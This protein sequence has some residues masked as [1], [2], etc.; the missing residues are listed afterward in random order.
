MA[1]EKFEVGK[2][3]RCLKD[4]DGDNYCGC[5]IVKGQEFVVCEVDT[6]NVLTR[7]V[8]F[9]CNEGLW[10]IYTKDEEFTSLN[11]FELIEGEEL[12]LSDTPQTP[13]TIVSEHE[14][15]CSNKTL[16][17]PH[18]AS[19]E[20]DTLSIEIP[21][22]NIKALCEQHSMK[23][24]IDGDTVELWTDFGDFKINDENDLTQVLDAIKVLEKFKSEEC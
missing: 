22:Q 10:A 3:Y 11:D 15:T 5:D 21:L 4:G 13:Q 6:H 7:D 16:T 9:N 20:V 12:S 1:I 24:L 23:V 18:D 19:E 17:T 2:K 8:T 14:H